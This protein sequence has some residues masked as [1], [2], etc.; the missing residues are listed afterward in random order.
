MMIH[1][2][3]LNLKN[4][5]LNKLPMLT[6]NN[7]II[8]KLLTSNYIPKFLTLIN[9]IFSTIVANLEWKVFTHATM[10]KTLWQ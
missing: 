10:N 7:Y 6:L 9:Y 5:S 1:K 4:I 8:I 3:L 2:L